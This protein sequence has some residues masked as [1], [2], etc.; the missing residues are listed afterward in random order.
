MLKASA[1]FWFSLKTSTSLPNAARTS[2][3]P[4]AFK[5]V[6]IPLIP[7]AATLDESFTSSKFLSIFCT[8]FA[9]PL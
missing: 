4:A 1:T 3:I 9:T 5:A 2:P 7:L 6:P 8:D